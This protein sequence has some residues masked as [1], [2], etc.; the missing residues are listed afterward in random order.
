M[1][2]ERFERRAMQE[3]AP[4]CVCINHDESILGASDTVEDPARRSARVFDLQRKSSTKCAVRMHFRGL[5]SQVVRTHRG[6]TG[7]DTGL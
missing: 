7:R 1:R 4:N 2:G 3:T 5:Y 6:A